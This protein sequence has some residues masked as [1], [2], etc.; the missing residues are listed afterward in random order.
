LR[1]RALAATG[2]H[3]SALAVLGA[4][5][6]RALAPEQYLE[7]LELSARSLEGAGRTA[8][9]ARRWLLLSQDAKGAQKQLALEQAAR[10]ALDAGDEVGVLFID[11][12]AKAQ[13]DA[14]SS[15]AAQVR[16]ARRRLGLEDGELPA[17]ATQRLERAEELATLG[18]AREA[19]EI[20]A[21]LELGEPR[22]TGA[23]LARLVQ[24][25]ARSLAELQGVDAALSALSGALPQIEDAEARRRI[26]LLAGEL[27]ERAGRLDEAIDAYQGR[28]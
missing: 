9:A 15:T 5:E 16:E 25:K 11:K 21:E 4:L 3:A 27:L 26:Y 2:A 17:E 1:A 24:V 7:T 12:L 10:L 23:A 18:R 14:G 6:A 8:D 20:A 13:L 28:L 22:P 19:L